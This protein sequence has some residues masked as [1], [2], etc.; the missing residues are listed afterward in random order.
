MEYTIIYKSV[1]NA[2]ARVSQDG[3]IKI[4]IPRLLR[5]N[6]IFEKEMVKQAEKLREKQQ[7]KTKITVLDKEKLQL[8]GEEIALSE[9]DFSSVKISKNKS[10]YDLF[11]QQTLL[12]YIDP[13]VKKYSQNL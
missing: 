8:F 10:K 7:K 11:F 3:S 6:K 1:K 4:T 5:Y 9:I 13:L 2:Y 12:E